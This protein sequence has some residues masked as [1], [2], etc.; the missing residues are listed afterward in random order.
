MM[1]YFSKSIIYRTTIINLDGEFY[2]IFHHKRVK[3]GDISKS[4]QHN[5]LVW[6][7]GVHDSRS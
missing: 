1:I 3:V 4:M 6:A 5:F 7:R 2:M